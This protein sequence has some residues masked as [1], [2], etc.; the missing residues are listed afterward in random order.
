MCKPLMSLDAN[1]DGAASMYKDLGASN[2]SMISDSSDGMEESTMSSSLGDVENSNIP[3]S[4]NCD[5]TEVHGINCMV[6]NVSNQHDGLDLSS[7][8]FASLLH[9]KTSKKERYML[10]V[11]KKFGVEHI[12]GDNVPLILRKWTPT[13]ELSQDELTSV[14]VWVKI[15]GVLAL[16]FI[17]E[18]LSAIST[19]LGTPMMLDSCIIIQTVEYFICFLVLATPTPS[20]N[21]RR[22]RFDI[23]T[24]SQ[25]IV[26][27]SPRTEEGGAPYE[28]TKIWSV[29]NAN[30][31]SGLG[32]ASPSHF[33]VLSKEDGKIVLWNIQESDDDDADVEN[34]CDDRATYS[35]ALGNSSGGN[36]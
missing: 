25:E 20:P 7:P 36:T 17:A 33:E 29:G 22:R 23:L 4:T 18:G 1:V 14:P 15:H 11:W 9:A 34:G 19:R 13:A 28:K 26:T 31:T 10:N 5:M 8:F 32:F 12:M 16:A 30:S 3:S 24:A 27:P 2:Q 21:S 6:G 35:K